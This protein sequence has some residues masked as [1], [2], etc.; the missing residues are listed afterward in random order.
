MERGS[1][2]Q[3]LLHDGPHGKNEDRQFRTVQL[4]IHE[5]RGRNL[6]IVRSARW[7][8][9]FGPDFRSHHVHSVSRQ[10]HSSRSS[11]PGGL[12]YLN[13]FPLPTRTDRAFSNF[14]V[15][16]KSQSVKY[17]TFDTRLDWNPSSRDQAFF[18]FSYDNS[19]TFKTNSFVKVPGLEGGDL[20]H[21]RGYAA[22]YTHTFTPNIVNEAHLGYNRIT[23]T[24]RLCY[25]A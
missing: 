12:P 20:T 17:N 25:T 24:T 23:Y 6:S 4:V 19:V 16:N 3:C 18:R 8:T 1:T 9:E 21:A 2:D 11:K 10:Y 7:N 13:S 5:W 22:G 15:S 14:L